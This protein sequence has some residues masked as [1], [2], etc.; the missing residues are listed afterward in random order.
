[1]KGVLQDGTLRLSEALLD[2]PSATIVGEGS[3]DLLGETVDLTLL[4]APL[5][6]V[7]SLI[8]RVPVLGDWLGNSVVS[9][10]VKVSGPLREPRVTPLAAS[11]VGE[12]LLGFM[13]RTVNLPV[14][15]FDR[16]RR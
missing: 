11:A 16:L 1:V 15:L 6:T 8:S 14:Q 3:I 7:D 2:A 9:I 5:K 13:K 10:P 12:Q 4:V